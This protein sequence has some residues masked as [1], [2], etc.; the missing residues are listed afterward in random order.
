[1]NDYHVFDGS[2]WMPAAEAYQHNG[3]TWEKV[4][5]L[6]IPKVNI[7]SV[8]Q[9]DVPGIGYAAVVKWEKLP[10]AYL[11][12][13]GLRVGSPA[14]KVDL[15]DEESGDTAALFI[16]R[17]DWFGQ[18]IYVGVVAED[19]ATGTWGDDIANISTVV[20]AP[21]PVAPTNLKA[22]LTPGSLTAA[23]SWTESVSAFV[24]GYEVQGG[25]T[26]GG[27][28]WNTAFNVTGS[29]FD[30]DTSQYGL[31]G[32]GESWEFRARTKGFGTNN[33]SGW[34]SVVRPGPFKDAVQQQGQVIGVEPRQPQGQ[35]RVTVTWS[36]PANGV[37]PK[38]YILQCGRSGYA[39]SPEFTISHDGSNT[40]EF[41]ESLFVDERDG[42]LW[43]FRMRAMNNEGEGLNGGWSANQQLTFRNVG[44]PNRP[45]GPLKLVSVE[46]GGSTTINIRWTPPDY[47]GDVRTNKLFLTN[48]STGRSRETTL[49]GDTHHPNGDRQ[50][51]VSVSAVG[52]SPYATWRVQLTPTN[53]YG[54]G[55]TADQEF[56]VNRLASPT[57][58]RAGA[59]TH[60]SIEILWDPV[61]SATAYA[62]FS[63]GTMRGFTPVPDAGTYAEVGALLPD[64]EHV[65]QVVSVFNDEVSEGS[66]LLPVRT[67]P[68]PD[69]A[70]M[71][72]A[73]VV[74]LERNKPA[75]NKWQAGW[76]AVPAAASYRLKWTGSTP[77]GGGH[78]DHTVSDLDGLSYQYTGT[79]LAWNETVTCQVAAVDAAGKEGEWSL[80]QN[81]V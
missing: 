50:S 55:P 24:Q 43:N 74:K 70:L 32:F 45:P 42:T 27:S 20:Q 37:T 18:T 36:A 46:R 80:P 44:M 76:S 72:P 66:E 11:Y 75:W 34:T 39:W 40:Y 60:D 73:P 16:G 58:L 78:G 35:R 65:F 26:K 54:D 49:D 53:N 63:N 4:W 5:P 31:S 56:T 2:T 30:F 51:N 71:L 52:G 62:V 1:M 48:V 15:R 69:E 9:K 8:E 19:L 41:P 77:E 38:R 23:L 14:E 29:T 33:F 7:L 57:N 12:R 17:P 67:A 68:A 21:A 10:G 6:G 61:E 79:D 25:N 47:G 13:V 59:V 3:Q 64:T 22:V 81:A 28:P